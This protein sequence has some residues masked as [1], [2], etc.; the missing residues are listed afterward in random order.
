MLFWIWHNFSVFLRIKQ[1]TLH[2]A[3]STYLKMK[4]IKNVTLWEL[5]KQLT[6]CW[7]AKLALNILVS[8]ELGLVWVQRKGAFVFISWQYCSISSAE[9]NHGNLACLMQTHS[10]PNSTFPS[11]YF[12]IQM[13]W[14]STSCNQNLGRGTSQ[15][16]AFSLLAETQE[17]DW[18][19]A[20]VTFFA[21]VFPLEH[22]RAWTEHA[23]TLYFALLITANYSRDFAC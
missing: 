1:K 6:I 5:N 12:R 21:G 14:S 17:A 11:C 2:S 18:V 10:V 19:N 22:Y 13:I 15:S 4:S 7:G 16:Q 3:V 20:L 9:L 8:P 23:S